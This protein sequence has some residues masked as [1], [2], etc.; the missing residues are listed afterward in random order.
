MMS[1]RLSSLVL[2]AV[3]VTSLA[4]QKR[5]RATVELP[6]ERLENPDMGL[7][8]ASV[9]SA[10]DVVSGDA[11]EWTFTA[12]GDNGD[13]TLTLM[14][15]PEEGG[16]INLVDAIKYRKTAFEEAEGGVYH[17]NRELGGPYGA[18]FTAR[19]SYTVDG[20]LVEETWAYAIHPGRNSLMSVR[21]TYPTGESGTRVEQ[22]VE[23][24]G[25]IEPLDAG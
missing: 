4:C 21:Y 9:P 1:T 10:F 5:P 19:G 25:E 18:I 3:L 14:V 2:A 7:A 22:L 12:P 15:G 24:L 8:I 13:G 20:T 17:G 11:Q 16:G 6:G 23:F